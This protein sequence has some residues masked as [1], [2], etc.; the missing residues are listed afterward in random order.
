MRTR[1]RAR[2]STVATVGGLVVVAVL[3]S[4]AYAMREYLEEQWLL[5]KFDTATTEERRLIARRLA[6]LGS[7]EGA[8]KIA[9]LL[10]EDQQTAILALVDFGSLS[11]APLLDDLEDA[12]GEKELTILTILRRIGSEGTDAL[13]R[14]YPDRPE[15]VRLRIL[16]FVGK[17]SPNDDRVIELYCRSLWDTSVSVRRRCVAALGAALGERH[18]REYSELLRNSLRRASED[19][20]EIVRR[21]AK[22]LL[23]SRWAWSDPTLTAVPA[24]NGSGAT[25]LDLENIR[26]D[27]GTEF[28]VITD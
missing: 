20:D 12:D 28:G 17:L 21:D 3:S 13:V 18:P 26:I 24:T 16:H 9:A 4:T 25:G 19:E 7:A 11:V 15:H 10:D 6:Q 27:F 5:H 8:R 2:A 14:E 23:E 22:R 1:R